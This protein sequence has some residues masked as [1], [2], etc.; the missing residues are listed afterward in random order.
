MDDQQLP[1]RYSRLARRARR[2]QKDVYRQLLDAS[3]E[4]VMEDGL[5]QVQ[6]LIDPEARQW[7]LVF[8]PK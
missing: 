7:T 8:I 2:R 3:G 6:R 1:R 4:R 5:S